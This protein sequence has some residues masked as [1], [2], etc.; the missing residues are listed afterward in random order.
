[1]GPRTGSERRTGILV[2]I[3]SVS[4]IGSNI[5]QSLAGLSQAEK[6]EAKEKR[7]AQPKAAERRTRKDEF[8]LV[9]SDTET[10]DAV[11]GLKSNDQE[12]TREDRQESGGYTPQGSR[13]DP[14]E[15]N[16]LDI[17]G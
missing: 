16:Q 10:A 17:E 8:D 4:T 6:I 5:A 14:N 11:R 1:M 2:D 7:P 13:T 9:V 3:E 15:S 12:D